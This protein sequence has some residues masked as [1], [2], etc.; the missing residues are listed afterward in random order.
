MLPDAPV[1]SGQ[2]RVDPGAKNISVAAHITSWPR[3]P[4]TVLQTHP[5]L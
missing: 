2:L 3:R 4:R 1:K 5:P